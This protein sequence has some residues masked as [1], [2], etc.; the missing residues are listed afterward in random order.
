MGLV[1][2]VVALGFDVG[3]VAMVCVALVE[4]DVVVVVVRV[5]ACA[6]IASC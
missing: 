3:I 5:C 2:L 6:Q 1:G 4:V